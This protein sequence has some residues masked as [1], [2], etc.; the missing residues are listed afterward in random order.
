MSRV[1]D[2]QL[3]AYLD[4][5]LDVA[6]TAAV[7]ETIAQDPELVRRAAALRESAALLRQAFDDVLHEPVPEHLLRAAR[8]QGGD[9]SHATV[10]R[11]PE[12]RAKR[13]PGDWQRWIS[14]PVAAS[15]M[16]LIV[17]GGL[18]YLAA[19]A[20]QFG[21]GRQPPNLSLAN[22]N[23]LDNIAGYHRMF[24]NAGPNDAGLVDIPA[25][26]QSAGARNLQQQLPTDFK[27]PDLKPWGLV[28]Q[29][30]RLLFIEGRPATQLF[31]TTDNQALGPITVVEASTSSPD[32][33]PTFDRRGDL[34]VLYWRHQGHI[35]AV[36]GTANIG[37]LWNIHNDLAWQLDAI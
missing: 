31:Y 27:P 30:A 12:R 24:V 29:G 33:Q 19:T 18:G 16:S 22:A 1:S 21:F 36:M 34:N 11:L 9:R 20:P 28:F 14:M 15:I 5:E 4:G 37:Y 32:I 25:N 35:Y 26:P 10:V 13:G 6:A 7:A 2:E 17:G 23:W 8:G 3:I